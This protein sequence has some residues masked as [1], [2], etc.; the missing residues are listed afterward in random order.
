MAYVEENEMAY[1]EKS[2]MDYV[3]ANDSNIDKILW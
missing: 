3:A 1:V 2:E